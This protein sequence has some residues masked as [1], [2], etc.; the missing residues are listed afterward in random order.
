MKCRG[1]N[2]YR[3]WNTMASK[4]WYKPSALPTLVAKFKPECNSSSNK[5]IKS[6]EVWTTTCIVTNFGMQRNSTRHVS[7]TKMEYHGYHDGQFPRC[8]TLINPANPFLTGPHSFP[9]FP[10]GGPQPAN[11]PDRTAH[12]I[13]GYV[14]QWG[15]MDVGNGNL[16]S[17]ISIC[18]YL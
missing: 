14:T 9:Y 15:G 10:R 6:I 13:M 8:S 12:H 16:K 7:H 18:I 5:S 1:P 11:P 3:F 4:A 17:C 2:Y